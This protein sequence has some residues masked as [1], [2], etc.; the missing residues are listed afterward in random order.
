MKRLPHC[1]RFSFLTA[2]L[3]VAGLPLYS[4][5][6]T[7]S[8]Q[9]EARFGRGIQVGRGF[10]GKFNYFENYLE[11]SAS[12]EQLRFYLRQAYRVPGEYEQRTAGLN[13][14]DK[15]YVEYAT[16]DY[17]VRGGDFYRVWG[18]GL[19]FGNL[20]V[21]DSNTDSGL[22]GLLVEGR[23]KGFEA[24]VL[25]GVES[26]ST[27][28]PRESAEG[29]YLS[30]RLPMDSRIGGAY[31]HFDAGSRHPEF[32]RHGIEVEK[33]FPV[34]SFYAVYTSDRFPAE[35][36]SFVMFTPPPERTHRFYHS[37]FANGALY[38]DGW[39]VYLDYRNYALY[40]FNEIVPVIGPIWQMSL[41]NPPT[42]RPENTFH[43]MD[44]YPRLVSYFDEI[45]YQLEL[46][47]NRWDWE[48]MANYNHAA[49]A[50][51][52]GIIARLADPYS[53][54]RSLFLK[55]DHSFGTG[56]RLGFKGGIQQDVEDNSYVSP[57]DSSYH[58]LVDRSK[59]FGLG[60]DYSHDFT[61][62]VALDGELQ[63]MSVANVYS[64]PPVSQYWEQ[65]MSL[66]ASRGVVS[67]TGGLMRSEKDRLY[68]GAAW[69]KGLLGRGGARCW[70]S[71][72]L[73]T[74]IL[75]RHRLEVFY[76]YERGGVSC[77]GGIC[78]VVNPFKG[79]KL[80]LTSHF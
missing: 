61:D 8:G 54:Q 23:Y 53:P 33:E 57:F 13:A 2:L 75:E 70:P 58:E 64:A 68:E 1:T 73:V 10:D 31:F 3:L 65:Y 27:T 36:W 56:D 19:L 67:L 42:G 63:I 32:E 45:G 5:G 14:F 77:A 71:A 55:A 25:R 29:F 79:V 74:Q 18:K 62:I 76:G 47:L 44:S 9:N 15:M 20:E 12:H 24:S 46:S 78:R 11:L 40:T 51:K 26:D 21:R 30:Q 50:D 49:L 6:F 41:Q 17:T 38:G 43:L 28:T 48:F 7:I 60:V 69:P 16:D 34:G 22:E 72:L 37:M 52:D 35:W 4:H 80:T 66:T 59:R 39:S